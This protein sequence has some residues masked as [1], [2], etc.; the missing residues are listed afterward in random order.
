MVPDFVEKIDGED[1]MEFDTVEK[2]AAGGIQEFVVHDLSV[3]FKTVSA[4]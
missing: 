4:L 3:V 2:Y 1:C